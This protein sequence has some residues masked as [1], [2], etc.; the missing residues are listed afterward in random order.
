MTSPF[1][2]TATGPLRYA[3][4]PTALG[5]FHI[6]ADDEAVTAVHYPHDEVPRDASWGTPSRPG[7]HPILAAAARQLTEFLAGER[8]TFDLPLRPRGTDFQRQAWAALL[9]IPYGQTRSYRE[10]AEAIARPTAVRAI[11]AANGANPIPIF[12]PCHRVIG[13][14]GSLTGYAG[15]TELKARLLD[16]ESGQVTFA[17]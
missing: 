5:A 9:T 2:P 12:I 8:R 14:G 6:V 10:Q 15:G 7:E 4:V 17:G 11:G 16:L 1:L 3:E 13:S